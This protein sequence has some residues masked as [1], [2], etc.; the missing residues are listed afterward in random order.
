MCEVVP[1]LATNA[2]PARARARARKV[3]ALP[4]RRIAHSFLLRADGTP[5]PHPED[6]G[7]VIPEED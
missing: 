4:Y 6:E 5:W 3:P 2:R 7:L 1:V